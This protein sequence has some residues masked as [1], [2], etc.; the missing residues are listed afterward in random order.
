MAGLM[1]DLA[2]A[3]GVAGDEAYIECPGDIAGGISVGD[4][5]E[6]QL[7]NGSSCVARV[8]AVD[9]IS[10][11]HRARV[12]RVDNGKIMVVPILERQASSDVD[13]EEP[14]SDADGEGGAMLDTSNTTVYQDYEDAFVVA[15]SDAAAVSRQNSKAEEV[16]NQEASLLNELK[17]E[18]NAT[19]Q[20]FRE[21]GAARTLWDGALE[22][23]DL[24]GDAA[25]VAVDSFRSLLPKTAAAPAQV[26]YAGVPVVSAPVTSAPAH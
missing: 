26:S 17:D 12:E 3:L 10:T 15:H 23:V 9:T 13:S 19:V 21:K 16:G 11:P 1:G 22:A 6:V 20:D 14:V 4:V 2:R 24:V 7:G 5:E 8:L 18:W 25:D